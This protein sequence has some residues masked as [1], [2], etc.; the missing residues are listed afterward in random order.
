MKV[1]IKQSKLKNKKSRHNKSRKILS[2]C[3]HCRLQVGLDRL[4][5]T[6]LEEKGA[7]SGGKGREGSE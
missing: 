4:L 7:K 5:I 6:V 3:Q 1:K 2:I